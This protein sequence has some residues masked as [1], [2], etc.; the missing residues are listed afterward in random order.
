MSGKKALFH[1]LKKQSTGTITLGDK[2]KCDILGIGKVALDSNNY[3][4]DVYL[5]DGLKYN[6][7]SILLLAVYSLDAFIIV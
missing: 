1:D 6:L 3:I 7:L 2:G 4:K 5:V